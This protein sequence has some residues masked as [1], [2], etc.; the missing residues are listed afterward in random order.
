[1]FHFADP[2]SRNIVR[3]LLN[4]ARFSHFV[5]DAPQDLIE[6][7]RDD[8]QAAGEL[9]C[10]IIIDN[11]FPEFVSD[12]VGDLSK[13]ATDDL[14]ALGDFVINI[15][16]LAPAILDDIEGDA[17]DV[18][19]VI[20]QLVTDPEAAITV[21][22]GGVESVVED[23]WHDIT[24]VGGEI[25]S[26][27]G[28]LFKNCAPSTPAEVLALVTA[29]SHIS[30]GAGSITIST[31]ASVTIDNVVSTSVQAVPTYVAPTAAATI[32]QT[33]EPT[34]KLSTT[35]YVYHYH[36]IEPPKYIMLILLTPGNPSRPTGLRA[37]LPRRRKSG[38]QTA[39]EFQY[40]YGPLRLSLDSYL[41]SKLCK[42][43]QPTQMIPNFTSYY[44]L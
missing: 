38:L 42:D 16:K 6:T 44:C 43:L 8:E 28:C 5:K 15:P 34:G 12:L 17:G 19:S 40:G 35:T 31:P 37:I 41:R 22:V 36:P 24:S 39:A 13:E 2:S 27:I 21:I 10:D 30:A 9:V 11:S 18:V 14:H 26:D 3:G 20:G 23:A 1:M 32:T 29:C 33:A 25:I 7:L 4:Q